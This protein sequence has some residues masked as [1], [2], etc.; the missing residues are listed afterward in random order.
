MADP[1][2]PCPKS[3]ILLLPKDRLQWKQYVMPFS[4]PASLKALTSSLQLLPNGKPGMTK[5]IVKSS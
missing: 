5:S 2:I 3:S 4:L 1:V